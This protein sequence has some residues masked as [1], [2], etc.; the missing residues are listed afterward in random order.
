MTTTDERGAARRR[1]IVLIGVALTVLAADI[2]S[3]VAIVATLSPLSQERLLGGFLTLAIYRN[4]GAAFGI[5]GP[6]TTVLFTAIAV[7][8]V[9]FIARY[10]RRI[11]STPWAIALGLLLGGAMGNLT[12]RLFRSPGFMQGWV[13][14]WIKLPHWPTFNV[15]DSAITCGAVLVVLLAARGTALLDRR[16]DNDQESPERPKQ[17]AR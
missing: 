15:A 10:S 2:A 12:D 13:V 14:D 11:T 16:P 6:S 3:K 1:V 4:P 9:V 5:G 8:V 7:A 17:A